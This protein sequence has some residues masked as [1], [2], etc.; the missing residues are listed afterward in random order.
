[1]FSRTAY[2]IVRTIRLAFAV[3]LLFAGFTCLGAPVHSQ[4]QPPTVSAPGPTP[5][6]QATMP[7]VATTPA[8][9]PTAAAGDAAAA[10]ARRKVCEAYVEALSGRS[11]DPELLRNREVQALALQVPD[12]VICGGV[13]RDSD[14]QWCKRLLPPEHGP[15]TECRLTQAVFHELHTY[16]Q[17]RSFLFHELDWE[18]C[19]AISSLPPTFCDALRQALRSGDP[20]SCA[21][22]GD[23]QS[24]CRAYLGLDASLCRV[25]GKVGELEL[26]VADF[27]RVKESEKEEEME[28]D[29][30]KLAGAGAR[31]KPKVKWW[32]EAACK[33]TIKSRAFLSKGLKAAAESGSPREREFAK[34][35]LGQADA[36]A[37]FAQAAM[38]ACMK[39]SMP[40]TAA[41]PVAGKRVAATPVPAKSPHRGGSPG[42]TPGQRGQ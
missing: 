22:T 38:D 33:D 4:T 10:K 8:E 25:Q 19:K 3:T 16:P 23:G 2:L 17:G 6:V 34:A 32:L 40:P 14:A 1:M 30:R 41:T 20:K 12:L 7:T 24:L 13:V 5:A 39:T 36:C 21:Q 11:K 28:A 18:E 26:H 15:D 27:P 9:S 35:A 42:P 37:S 29:L 31:E